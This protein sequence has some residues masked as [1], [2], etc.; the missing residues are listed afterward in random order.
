MAN[1]YKNYT[2]E[3]VTTEVTIITAPADTEITIVGMSVAAVGNKDSTVSIKLNN[4]YLLK[5]TSVSVGGALIPIGGEQKV[6]LMTD[7]TLSISS[8]REVDVIVSTIEKV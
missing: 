3:A 5:E 6:I 2:A 8:D 1:R 7:D 4:T